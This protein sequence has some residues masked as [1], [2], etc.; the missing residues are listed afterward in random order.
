MSEES[1][2]IHLPVF[3]GPFDLLLFFIERDEID[4]HDIPIS[5]IT[6]DFLEYIHSM[7]TMNMDI[8]AE[9]ILVAGTLMRIKAKMLIPRPTFNE[10][11]EEIDPREEL[12]QR[13]LEYK[14]YKE[15]VS[16]LEQK[17]AEQAERLPRGYVGQ[18]EKDLLVSELPEEELVGLDLFDL[19]RTFKRV[20]EAHR[21]QLSQPKH[22]IR[23]YPYRMEE[24]KLELLEQLSQ[25]S[26]MDFISFVL[27]KPDRIFFVFS[28]LAVLEM[29]QAQQIGVTLGIGYNNFWLSRK[30]V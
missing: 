15:V 16:T 23:P 6:Q 17:E 30:T 21:Q 9:F 3:E 11:G 18:E 1:Y 14:K 2:R 26:R 7:Q 27:N 22:V 28:F 25:A 20:W 5:R 10:A 8:A 29:T 4:I 12:V 24:V 13:L 19:L